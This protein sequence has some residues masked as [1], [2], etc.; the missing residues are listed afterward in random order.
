LYIQVLPQ[1]V[2]GVDQG[3]GLPD[4]VIA[5]S[6][7]A[8]KKLRCRWRKFGSRLLAR[9][10]ESAEICTTGSGGHWSDDGD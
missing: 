6:G 3:I 8:V 9:S 4:G 10:A 5:Y 1:G 2:V 7:D